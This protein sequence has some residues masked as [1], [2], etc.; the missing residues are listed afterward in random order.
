MATLTSQVKLDI[1]GITSDPIAVDKSFAYTALSGGITS[2][3][4][5]DNAD[6]GEKILEAD[7]YATGTIV[8][9]RNREA[10]GGIAI[11]IQ[12]SAA[13]GG[14]IILQGQEWCVF[15][16]TTLVDV[17]AFSASGAPILEIGVFSGT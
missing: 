13:A 14:E 16:W 1:S 11:T 7:E 2:R 10:A 9:L 4:I 3:S 8:Y 15:P 17:L 5:N 6:P 12:L